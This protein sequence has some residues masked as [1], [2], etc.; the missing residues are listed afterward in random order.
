MSKAY[1]RNGKIDFLKFFF[2]IIILLNH[3]QYFM[4]KGNIADS[5]KG[6]SFGVEFFF[7]VSGYLLMASISRAEENP[8]GLSLSR[9][10]GLF[11]FKKFKSV[12]PEV[13]IAYIF[14]LIAVSVASGT[15]L[16]TNF[17]KS[18]SEVFLITSTGVRFSVFNP[19]IWYISSMLLCM[20]FLYPFIRKYKKSVCL[21][22]LP[23]I[24]LLTLGYLAQVIGNLRGPSLWLG[25]TF[26][27]NLRALGEL[28]LGV[29]CYFATEKLRSID[30][31]LFGRTL[32]TVLEYGIYAAYVYYMATVINSKAD[33]FFLALL[34]VAVCISFSGKGI[35]T[36]VFS[37]RFCSFLGKFSLPLFLSHRFYPERLLDLFPFLDGTRIRYQ[38]IFYI[39]LSFATA[40]AVMIIS[41][42]LRKYGKYITAF[43]KKIILSK[44]G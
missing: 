1:T 8:S 12:Y 6:Y 42:L 31:N 7:L 25:F 11:I 23:V 22:V 19:V 20:V 44:A 39:V 34:C 10:T 24:A 26:R 28:S 32:L 30:F 13:F 3:A 14:A 9:E 33:F 21:L 36:A 2:S 35:D 41:N 38:F 18:W 29:L 4:P 16:F 17:V 15:S 5:F 37:N 43:F 40:A 27:G